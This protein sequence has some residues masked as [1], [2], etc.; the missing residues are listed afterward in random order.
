MNNIV[1]CGDSFS[2]GIGCYNLQ[3][4]PYGS[5][6]ANHFGKNLINLAKGS[7]S[8]LS[9][10]LQAKYA[11]EHIKDID[12]VCVAITSYN[13]TEWFPEDEHYS[14]HWEL[15]NT[16]VNYH[17]YPP[18]SKDTYHTTLKHPMIDNN[19]YTGKMFTE[20]YLGIVDYVDNVLDKGIDLN[21]FAKFKNER[22]ERMRLLKNYFLEIFD[23][24]IQRQYD[25]GMITLAHTLL[26]NNGIKHYIL[27]WDTEFKKY[28]PNENL[29]WVDWGELSLKY[30]DELGSYHT[31]DAGHKIVFETL[32]KK[33]NLK[34]EII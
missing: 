21:Y 22:P 16:N 11:V 29:V 14:K 28:I 4:E 17:Q 26:K 10:F 12:F 34:K 30:P 33:I 24:S 18:Y 13:R 15:D 8:N 7:S 9:I 19:F 25:I 5:L 31:S 1:I 3:K 6:L 2:I 20:N 27:T 23:E 32:L